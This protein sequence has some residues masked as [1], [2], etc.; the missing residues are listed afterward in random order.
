MAVLGAWTAVASAAVPSVSNGSFEV[1]STDGGSTY[2]PLYPGFGG[3]PNWRWS[4]SPLVVLIGNPPSNP[5]YA[6][7]TPFGQ[8]QLDLSGSDNTTGG[9]IETDLSDL[10]PGSRYNLF[11][12][13]GTSRDFLAGGGPP[14][15]QVT[16]DGAQADRFSHLPA[17][18]VEWTPLTYRFTANAANVVLRFTDVAPTGTGLVSVDDLRLEPVVEAPPTVSVRRGEAPGEVLV[19][20][21]GTLES[22]L[23]L[24]TWLAVPGAASP[25]TATDDATARWYRAR[26]P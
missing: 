10:A 14:S 9:W 16:I 3:L 24:R 4:S 19:D 2:Q 17:A 26:L 1:N 21:T 18:A 6:Y 5:G 8:W 11:F 15:L 7:A 13:F 12:K 22:S 20:F 25:W 23:D